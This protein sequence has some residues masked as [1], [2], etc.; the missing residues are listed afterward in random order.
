MSEF[1]CTWFSQI[2]GE[3]LSSDRTFGNVGSHYPLVN[4][5][6][7]WSYIREGGNRTLSGAPVGWSESI[8][9]L[10]TLNCNFRNCGSGNLEGQ[11]NLWIAF[12]WNIRSPL[13][14]TTR[15]TSRS[16]GRSDSS[17]G[18]FSAGGATAESSSTDSSSTTESEG[19][20]QQYIAGSSIYKRYI[21]SSGI[22]EHATSHNLR[23]GTEIVA[24]AGSDRE[25]YR[26]Y[27]HHTQCF[28]S[29]M[30]GRVI[31]DSRGHM[32]RLR[33]AAPGAHESSPSR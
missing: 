32:E 23:R 27:Q 2:W 7:T 6:V 21:L 33:A 31:Q 14:R 9:R 13:D 25:R 5:T 24:F 29:A 26:I 11:R 1:S 8:A 18:S 16:E 3:K 28:Y 10:V 22:I 20:Q 17:G 12:L 30:D 19:F 15:G 4:L